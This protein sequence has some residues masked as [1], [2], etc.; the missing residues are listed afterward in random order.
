LANVIIAG[1]TCRTATHAGTVIDAQEAFVVA[2]GIAVDLSVF[3]TVI[4]AIRHC[5]LDI[6]DATRIFELVSFNA[7]IVRAKRV[8]TASA[9]VWTINVAGT[10][11]FA[12][13]ISQVTFFLARSSRAVFY[14]REKV[15]L[16]IRL[17]KI[18]KILI[19]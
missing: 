1:A 13:H 6:F 2:G 18:C 4:V 16:A 3:Q 12:K 19:S 11:C 15:F 8:I 7:R 9:S 5:F 10:L 17:A 14:A